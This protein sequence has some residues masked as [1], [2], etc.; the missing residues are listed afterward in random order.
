LKHLG[1]ACNK[2]DNLACVVDVLRR[3]TPT[4]E[5]LELAGNPLYVKKW[6]LIVAA[7]DNDDNNNAIACDTSNLN[8]VD[9][10]TPLDENLFDLEQYSIVILCRYLIHL[11]KLDDRLLARLIE[12]I[13]LVKHEVEEQQSHQQY[14]KKRKAISE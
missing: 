13:D 6:R 11:K 4:L 12:R 14:S 8:I 5:S 7:N 2:L 10:G 3:H 1:L 9:C